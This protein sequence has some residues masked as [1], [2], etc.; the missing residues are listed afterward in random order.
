VQYLTFRNA[1]K[2]LTRAMISA[3]IQRT[4]VCVHI[5]NR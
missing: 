3:P 4:S 5:I 1:E 2:K